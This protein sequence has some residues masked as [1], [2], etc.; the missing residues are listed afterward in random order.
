MLIT[1]GLIA[2]NECITDKDAALTRLTELLVENNKVEASYIEGMRAREQQ[3]NTYLDQGIAIPHGTPESRCDIHETAIAFLQ[4]PNG[5]AWGEQGETATLLIGIAAKGD[6]HLD[7]LR[8]LTGILDDEQTLHTLKTT[9]DKAL[10]ARILNGEESGNAKTEAPTNT[11]ASL[12]EQSTESKGLIIGVTSC[13]TGIAHTFMAAESLNNAAK[14]LGYRVNIETQG[15][16]GTQDTLSDRDISDAEVV[17]IASDTSVDLS[18][19]NGKRIYQTNTKAAI[20]NGRATI[21]RALAEASLLNKRSSNNAQ[22]ASPQSSTSALSSVYKHLM[23]GVSFMLPF[24]VAGGLLIALGFAFGSWQFGDQGIYIYEAEYAGSIGQVLFNT[25]KAAFA[26]FVP[27]LGG[28]IAYSIAGRAA[29][30]PGMVGGFL[31]NSEGSGFIGAII[32]GFIAGYLI[33]ALTKWIKL[34]K[35]LDGLKPILI[36]PL[37]GTMIVGL[38]MFYLIGDPVTSLNNSLTTWLQSISGVNAAVLGL[39]LGAMMAVDMGGPI[40]KAAY[41]FATGLIGSEVYAPMAAVMAAG[42]TPPLAI[43]FASIIRRNLFSTEEREAAKAAGV[44]GLAF[45]TEGAIP[46]AA[47]DPLRVIPALI[48]GS[49]I[50]GAMSMAFDCLLRAP[51]GGLFVLFVPN[52]VSNLAMYILSIVIGTAVST[53]AL[54]L[55]KPRVSGQA[56]NA[57]TQA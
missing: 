28:Y 50:A 17:I 56:V 51:H 27:I 37:L 10:I 11:E 2:T 7:I 34:P 25:G 24:V 55:L 38:L 45:I 16:V 9:N 39:I 6:E 18:R 54:I 30:A 15:S 49:A 48:A 8:R 4:V 46:F 23:T 43:F 21:E 40:N 33:A 22:Q 41:V 19:F 5:I 29:I 57:P 13:P 26:L 52:A 44:M 53:A 32:A 42:M 47:R 14:A 20:N 35:S 1:T 36:L 31:A 12:S 3:I